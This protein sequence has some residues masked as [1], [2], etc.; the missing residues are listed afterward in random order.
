MEPRQTRSMAASQPAQ[1]SKQ[2]AYEQA[3]NPVS[4]APQEQ[5]AQ[6]TQTRQH[7]DSLASITRSPDSKPSSEESRARLDAKHQR[8]KREMQNASNVDEQ[9]GVEQQ[10]SE[11]YI[12]DAVEHKGQG[13]ERA[14][15]G[16]HAGPVGSGAGPGHPGFGEERD[17]AAGMDQK[18]AEHDRMLGEKVGQSPPA[19]ETEVAEREAVRQRKLE[20][21]AS[22]NAGQAVK[23]ATG[24]P[25]VPSH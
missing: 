3:S 17:L 5:R 25:V 14:Q 6:T 9:Y 15:A 19:P 11:G 2:A 7:G 22:V 1:P 23:E 10:P 4:K 18:R 21:N 13:M 8:E 20:Q 16:A 12:A 24:E